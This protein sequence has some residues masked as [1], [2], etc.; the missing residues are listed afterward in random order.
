MR[1][2][3]KEQ[4]KK[5]KTNNNKKKPPNP[6]SVPKSFLN[7]PL[8][9]VVMAII[10]SLAADWVNVVPCTFRAGVVV[11]VFCNS[12]S[13]SVDWHNGDF[14]DVYCL[15]LKTALWFP[16][17]GRHFQDSS[18]SCLGSAL[19]LSSYQL[20]PTPTPTVLTHASWPPVP[21]FRLQP[22]LSATCPHCPLL[23]PVSLCLLTLPPCSHPCPTSS[24]VGDTALARQYYQ[25]MPE[26][27]FWL[28]GRE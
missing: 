23:P 6:E 11:I 22:T 1:L 7:A 3:K 8:M 9:E 25:D 27:V 15:K 4:Q 17:Q 19:Q 12:V 28:G 16:F 26:G 18:H 24:W 13:V 10:I 21:S 2:K 14:P 5:K 20:S